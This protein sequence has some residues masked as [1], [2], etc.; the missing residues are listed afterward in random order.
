MGHRK[1]IQNYYSDMNNL[2]DFL[3][4]LVNSYRLLI[5]GA[6]ELNQIALAKKGEVKNALDRVDDL[7]EIIDD[8]IKVL[9]SIGYNY[10]DYCKI[11]AQI[12]KCKDQA[13]YIETEI[14][15]ELKFEESEH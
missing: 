5:G 9:D 8:V 11:K 13:Q 12:I 1:V 10:I 4:K 7:G 6:A 15:E 2:A 14:D 3:A